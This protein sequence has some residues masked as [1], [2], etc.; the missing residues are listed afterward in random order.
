M[1]GRLP[2]AILWDLDG[3]LRVGAV[4][5]RRGL[6]HGLRLWDGLGCAALAVP[7][8]HVMEDARGLVV[9]PTLE[10]ATLAGL[11]EVYARA[12]GQR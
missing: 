7:T 4:P 1:S 8:L 6:A 12:T 2:S 9:L 5:G 3:A 11:S 10:G